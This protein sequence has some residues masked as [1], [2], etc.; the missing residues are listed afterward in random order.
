MRMK[1]CILF[2]GMLACWIAVPLSAQRTQSMRANITGG[3]G[4]G[5]CTFEVV[6]DGVAEVEIRGGQ[7]FLR[8]ISGNPATWRRLVCNQPLPSRPND[9]RFQGIDGR[10]RQDLVRDPNSNG[11]TAVIR[12][13]DPKSGS[14][15][16]TG[17]IMW[18]GGSDDRG[19]GPGGYRD[20]DRGYDQNRDRD[21]RGNLGRRVSPDDAANI[22]RSE[23]S[24]R[25][26]GGNNMRMEPATQAPDGSYTVRFTVRGGGPPRSGFCSV[27]PNGRILEFQMDRGRDNGRVSRD[28]AMRICQQEVARRQSMS[29]DDVRVQVNSESGDGRYLISFQARQ[30]YGRNRSGS[31]RVSPSGQIEAIQFR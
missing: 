2:T 25:N 1:I 3:S 14:E 16:Y 28:Q 13:E 7:G 20:R 21:Q 18:R 19:G 11:G 22:C 12:I 15:G 10:G 23:I 4:D 27:S 29:P 9:F 26:V 17:D 5:K 6:V 24:N 31:C 30:N 8:T